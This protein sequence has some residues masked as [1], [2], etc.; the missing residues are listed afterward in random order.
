MP[1]TGRMPD[2]GCALDAGCRMRAGCRMP[3]ARW[4]PDAGC[5]LD[6]C[7]GS[8]LDAGAACRVLLVTL[9]SGGSTL[10]SL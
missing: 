4:M 6:A 9:D 5:A 3:D 1:D 8:W 7:A 10:E 2:A